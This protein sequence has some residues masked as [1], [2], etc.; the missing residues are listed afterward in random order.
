MSSRFY[1]DDITLDRAHHF[2]MDDEWLT[3]NLEGASTQI[4]P[5]WRNQSLIFNHEDARRT[6]K[7]AILTGEAA[8]IIRQSAETLIFLGIEGKVIYCAADLSH[9]E[10]P[11]S[12]AL[13]VGASFEDLRRLATA[14]DPIDAGYLA[15]ARALVHWHQGHQFCGVCG[16]NTKAG[17]G[18]HERACLN[19][20]CGRVHFPRT[21]PAVIML[22]THPTEE[23]CLLG[24][25][26]KFQ[27]LRFSTVA[28]F[29]EP[30]EM[31]EQAVA[32]EV[33]EETNIQ[34][35][36][37]EYKASQP[38]PFPASIMLGFRA[39]AINTDIICHDEELSEARWFSRQEVLDM[40]G[41]KEMLPPTN[42]SIS[43]W[44]I[45][46]WLNENE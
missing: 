2:R 10:D 4:V 32:R 7:A 15:Y 23:K 27:G 45:D 6:P 11:H 20:D 25:N 19:S 26:K 13:P 35:V 42:L 9:L 39:R 37:V 46:G 44:L 28:G 3:A 36:D 21:D 16:S 12:I 1:Y 18:G 30:G 34:V 22:V 5:V 24:H 31:L 43:R 17:R 8:D 14:L 41:A 29:V 38:W 33:Y 40:A